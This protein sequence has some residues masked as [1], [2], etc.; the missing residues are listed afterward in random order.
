MYDLWLSY[1]PAKTVTAQLYLD[2]APYS[3]AFATSE[4]GGIGEYYANVPS[5]TAANEYVVVFFDG[6]TKVVSGVLDWD[7]TKE[8]TQAQSILNTTVESTYSVGDSLRLANSVL[9]GK[10][11]GAQ[12]GVET[13]RDLGD[14]KDRLVSTV[15]TKGNRS[16]EAYN[17]SE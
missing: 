2:N 6:S 9:G 3:A 5:G 17:L 11:S 15:D 8:V 10:I 13:F 4:V 12:S 1:K 14:T 7:G 16:V